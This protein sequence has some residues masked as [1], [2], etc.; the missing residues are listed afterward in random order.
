MQNY[1][2]KKCLSDKLVSNLE[3]K[4]KKLDALLLDMR[5]WAKLLLYANPTLET[6]MD[7]SPFASQVTLQ[8]NLPP[9]YST[10]QSQPSSIQM[11]LKNIYFPNHAYTPQTPC[12]STSY[13]TRALSHYASSSI[14]NTSAPSSL[15]SCT[16]HAISKPP[17]SNVFVPKASYAIPFG[18]TSD[19]ILV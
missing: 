6:K 1:W 4:I 7:M 19:L 10:S 8:N 17:I 3:Q 12:T 13:F 5:E 2:E 9:D 18:T 16:S 15:A 11:L 14:R